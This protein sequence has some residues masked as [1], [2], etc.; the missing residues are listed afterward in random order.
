LTVPFSVA[1]VDVISVAGVVVTTGASGVD[2]STSTLNSPEVLLP[3]PSI[4]VHL[5]VVS[6]IGNLLAVSGVHF[7]LSTASSRPSAETS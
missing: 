5:T 6:P 1:A 2:D 3:W 7:R 4:A